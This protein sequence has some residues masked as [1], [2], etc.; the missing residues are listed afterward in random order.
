MVLVVLWNVSKAKIRHI[1]MVHLLL[2][3]LLV[4][5]QLLLGQNTFS[6][7]RALLNGSRLIQVYT[8]YIRY[9][10]TGMILV[11]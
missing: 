3:S 4:T 2:K 11:R 9:D 1:M 10:T 7:E 5:A 6:G 8:A